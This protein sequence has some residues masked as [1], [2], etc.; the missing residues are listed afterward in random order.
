MT[1]DFSP[2]GYPRPTAGDIRIETLQA[3]NKRLLEALRSEGSNRYWEGRWRDEAAENEKL[4][5]AYEALRSAAHDV[6]DEAYE[7]ELSNH[8]TVAAPAITKLARA[9]RSHEHPD[10]WEIHALQAKLAE[11]KELSEVFQRATL[12]LERK[13]TGWNRTALAMRDAAIKDKA[14]AVDVIQRLYFNASMFQKFVEPDPKPT[15]ETKESA[16]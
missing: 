15:S 14:D 2:H 10:R 12:M 11:C 6:I 8:Y 16:Q 13:I 7:Q 5:A 3:E 4:T 9:Y 1:S